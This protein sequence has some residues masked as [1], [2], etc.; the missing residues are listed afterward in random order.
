[1]SNTVRFPHRGH[2][3]E[4]GTPDTGDGRSGLVIA[5]Q[6][7]IVIPPTAGACGSVAV[8]GAVIHPDKHLCAA[9]KPPAGPHTMAD[10]T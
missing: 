5:N 4:I 8:R 2:D 6:V 9:G 3:S 7:W 10:D 1:M